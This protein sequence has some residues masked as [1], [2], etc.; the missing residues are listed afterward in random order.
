MFSGC[1]G[2]VNN[3]E[4]LEQ[5]RGAA[6]TGACCYRQYS[7]KVEDVIISAQKEEFGCKVRFL[8]NR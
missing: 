3:Y 1:G 7:L 6:I 5:C 8:W 2:N 4:T